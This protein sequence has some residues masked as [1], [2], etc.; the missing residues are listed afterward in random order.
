MQ[1]ND[2]LIALE[3]KV[4]WLEDQ[5]ESQGAEL[6]QLYDKLDKLERQ[7]KILYSKVGDPY[8]TRS[9]KDEVPPPHY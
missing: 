1:E 3:E 9:Q 2:K 8:A 4:A 6:S 5:L 7:F